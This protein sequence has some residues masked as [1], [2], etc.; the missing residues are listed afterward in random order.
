MSRLSVTIGVQLKVSYSRVSVNRLTRIE[1]GHGER[2]AGAGER[3]E[4]NLGGCSLKKSRE[5]IFLVQG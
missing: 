5:R 4:E 3:N 2:G 1:Q